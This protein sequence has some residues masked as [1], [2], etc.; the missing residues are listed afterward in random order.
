[1]YGGIFSIRVTG[2]F[3]IQRRVTFC[4]YTN[5]ERICIC[6]RCWR[7]ISFLL[8]SMRIHDTRGYDGYDG[9]AAS[10]D[11]F[12]FS[13]GVT[14]RSFRGTMR[15]ITAKNKQA[16]GNTIFRHDRED[17]WNVSFAA[18]VQSLRSFLGAGKPRPE[19]CGGIKLYIT[20]IKY[21]CI[22]RREV[23]CLTASIRS[24][25]HLAH[26]WWIFAPSSVK[27]ILRGTCTN[28]SRCRR[29]WS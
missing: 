25:K 16:E 3:G 21:R 4:T 20:R 5:N 18:R 15:G 6:T 28:E 11:T 12:L 1:M 17:R 14:K 24:A 13:V 8:N 2:A 23:G 29:A 7:K 19:N 26:L 22:S 10:K 9:Y 27:H